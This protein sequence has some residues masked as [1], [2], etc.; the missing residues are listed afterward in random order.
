LAGKKIKKNKKISK[1]R[2]RT[3]KLLKDVPHKF[4]FYVCNGKILKNVGELRDE[5]KTMDDGTFTHHVN[6]EKNDFSNWINDIIK[7][8]KLAKDLRNATNTQKA[9]ITVENRIKKTQ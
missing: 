5:L 8:K 2:L 7:D 4:S 3:S 9:L 1:N 6:Q